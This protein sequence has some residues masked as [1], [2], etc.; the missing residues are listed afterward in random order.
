MKA[1]EGDEPVEIQ[2]TPTD[3][4]RSPPTPPT[5][6]PARPDGDERGPRSGADENADGGR[7]RTVLAVVAVGLA[8]LGLGW[9]LGRATSDDGDAGTVAD[10]TT[11]RPERSAAGVGVTLPPV[12]DLPPTTAEPTLRT[13]TTTVAVDSMTIEVEPRLADAPYELVGLGRSG[14]LIELDLDEGDLT[15]RRDIGTT[16]SDGPSVVWAGTGWAVVPDWNRGSTWLVEDGE[17]PRPLALGPPWQIFEAD[18]PGEFWILDDDLRVGAPGNAQR[19]DRRG[20]PLD[21]P[22]QLSE[23]PLFSDPTGGLVVQATGTVY[24]VDA[25]GVTRIVDGNLLALDERR[26]VART[27]DDQLHCGYVVVDRTTGESSD[28]PI[29]DSFRYF[30]RYWPTIDATRIAPDGHTMAVT[31]SD[32]VTGEALGL[33]D[34]DTGDLTPL[35]RTSDGTLRWTPDARFALYLDAG[36]PMAHD[37]EAGESFVIADDLPR[38]NALAI[39]P[40]P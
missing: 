23:I 21:A 1:V 13:T 17:R 7:R 15:V 27:C 36:L 18:V 8:A 30:A 35:S 10:T 33:I 31:W 12:E 39:R 5:S 9:M 26:A 16:A 37:I 34:L 40:A 29:D 32:P 38:L 25:D 19:V 24:R 14:E 22:V 28:L 3:P 6:T 2:L 11:P 4:R 20:E